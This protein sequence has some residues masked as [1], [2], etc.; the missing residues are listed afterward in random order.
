MTN[1]GQLNAGNRT[2]CMRGFYT[3]AGGPRA[4]T[5]ENIKLYEAVLAKCGLGGR[6]EHFASLDLS[7]TQQRNPAT[8]NLQMELLEIIKLDGTGHTSP[9]Q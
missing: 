8:Q 6:I 4:T 5:E 1:I 3:T 2:A 7:W 9:A